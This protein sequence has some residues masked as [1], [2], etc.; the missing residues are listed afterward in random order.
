MPDQVW[1][2]KQPLMATVIEQEDKPNRKQRRAQLA[3][4]K[5]AKGKAELR[6]KAAERLEKAKENQ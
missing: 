5:S 1:R 4:A 2:K 3:Y 6:R